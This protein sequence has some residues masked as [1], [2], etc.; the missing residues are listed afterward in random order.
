VRHAEENEMTAKLRGRVGAETS[1]ED[2]REGRGGKAAVEAQW[3]QAI[4][5]ALDAGWKGYRAWRHRFS[6]SSSLA[7]NTAHPLM[8]F[9]PISP[10]LLSRPIATGVIGIR[11]RAWSPIR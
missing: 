11:L 7:G 3:W 9:F 4:W 10:S 2:L 8:L 5:T 6:L 1:K